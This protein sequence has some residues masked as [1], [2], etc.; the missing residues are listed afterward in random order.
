MSNKYQNGKIY[1]IVD[2][3]YNKCY[4]GSTCEELSQRMA[5]HRN[6]YR[7]FNKKPRGRCSVY[8]LFEEFGVENCKIE[9]VEEHPCNN[10]M[11]LR[12]KEGQHIQN[13]EGVNKV[14]A[15]RT[16][17]EYYEQTEEQR[18]EY[19]KNN[20][21]KLKHYHQLYCETNKDKIKDY[22]HQNKD[23]IKVIN[24][25]YYDKNEEKRKEYLEANKIKIARYH[26][27]YR[28]QH[29]DKM[30]EIYERRK[31]KDKVK[32]WCDCGGCYTTGHRA[33]HMKTLKH[34]AYYLQQ[35]QEG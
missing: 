27:L 7:S 35:Q 19:V 34:Q 25:T 12:R 1:K 20:V 6:A 16:R 18:K 10:Q 31:A 28:A 14:I 3:G 24:K 2:V 11:E 21:E 13:L 29:P 9:L 8:G 4:I 15:G 33:T 30:K 23:K 17:K 32:V 22:K 5:R 26:Q